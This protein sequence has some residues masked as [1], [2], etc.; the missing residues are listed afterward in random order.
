MSVLN[1]GILM[2]HKLSQP[3]GITGEELYWASGSS[4]RFRA[5]IPKSERC[6]KDFLQ[7]RVHRKSENCRLPFLN[8]L[9]AHY[10]IK[11]SENSQE[12]DSLIYILSI[13]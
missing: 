12:L 4:P 1:W 7:E 6:S 3:C 8:D 10:H 5:A 13:I 9:H 11:S 2:V